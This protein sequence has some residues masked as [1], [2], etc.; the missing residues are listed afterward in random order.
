MN[1]I[2]RLFGIAGLALASFPAGAQAPQADLKTAQ[3]VVGAMHVEPM[4]DRMFEQLMP[5]MTGSVLNAMRSATDTPASLRAKLATASGRDQVSAIIS[6][7][8]MKA[9]R[10]HYPQIA[11]AMVEEYRRTFTTGELQAVLAFYQS[12][13]GAKLLATQPQIQ[14]ALSRAG[15][16]IG[17]VAGQEA[18]PNIQR[19][20]DQ[21][22]RPGG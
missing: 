17:R 5:L 8:F 2:V 12:P 21:L 10:V 1:R 18:L 3:A 9:F 4:L 13:A 16:E 6:D 14:A 22:A 7:E 19:R 11:G 15:G 20:L